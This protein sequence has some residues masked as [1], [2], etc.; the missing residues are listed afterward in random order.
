MPTNQDYDQYFRDRVNEYMKEPEALTA[1]ELE[2]VKDGYPVTT[3][4][5]TPENQELYKNLVQRKLDFKLKNKPRLAI[6]KAKK[7][8]QDK[9]TKDK[10]EIE[11]QTLKEKGT[12]RQRLDEW[13]HG[14]EASKAQLKA[15]IMAIKNPQK[16]YQAIKE[17]IDIF[18]D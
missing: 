10:E 16:R 18:S 2:S 12:Y 7:D 4:W 5:S 6:E 15:E 14:E 1:Q 13:Q 8:T 17:N 11:K 9:I 3:D